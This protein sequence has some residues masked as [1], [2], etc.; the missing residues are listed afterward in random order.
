MVNFQKIENRSIRV[1]ISSTFRDMHAER[2][3]LAKYTFPGIAY[4]IF[5]GT[6]IK[7]GTLKIL[8]TLKF[9]S[10]IV[11]NRNLYL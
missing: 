1:F 11:D 3:E 7:I 4:I 10:F 2:E 8:K 6:W 9:N 5:K